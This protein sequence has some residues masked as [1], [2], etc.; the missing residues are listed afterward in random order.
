[1]NKG[2]NFVPVSG[3]GIQVS[4]HCTR[5]KTSGIPSRQEAVWLKLTRETNEDETYAT[6]T[7]Y[8]IMEQQMRRKKVFSEVLKAECYHLPVYI[9]L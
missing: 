4:P 7:A 5:N 3:P 1:M 9:A 8:E 2:K 6:K